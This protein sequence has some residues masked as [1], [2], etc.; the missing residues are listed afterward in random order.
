MGQC[1]N[2][3]VL[4]DVNNIRATVVLDQDIGL[5][6]DTPAV[7]ILLLPGNGATWCYKCRCRYLRRRR[8]RPRYCTR[9]EIGMRFSRL[10]GFVFAG[11]GFVL[12]ALNRAT[13]S[14]N[15]IMAGGHHREYIERAEW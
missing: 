6:L 3:S 7:G 10:F 13:L 12:D 5:D 11:A 9:L 15:S 14:I 8:R 2:K 4:L 1:T